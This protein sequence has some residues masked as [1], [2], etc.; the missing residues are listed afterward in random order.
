M[1]RREQQREIL[2]IGLLA[3]ALFVLLALLPV[4]V[5]G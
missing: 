1:L 3:L 5:L 4:S 2:A